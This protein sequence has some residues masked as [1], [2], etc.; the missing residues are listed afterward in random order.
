MS[1]GL[2]MQVYDASVPFTASYGYK[3]WGVRELP[4][5]DSKKGR[6]AQ[7]TSHL[8]MLKELAAVPVSVSTDMILQELGQRPP[9]LAAAHWQ[10]LECLGRT[11]LMPVYYKQIALDNCW[12]QCFTR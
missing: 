5:G 1:V 4:T 8:R 7:G 9:S 3:V 6:K 2:L 11:S 10:V 12:V